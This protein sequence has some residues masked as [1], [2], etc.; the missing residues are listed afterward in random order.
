MGC[1]FR[2]WYGFDIDINRKPCQIVWLENKTNFHF[3]KSHDRCK[4]KQENKAIFMCKK[5]VRNRKTKIEICGQ[6]DKDTEA[7]IEKDD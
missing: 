7:K 4:I 2:V 3:V 1:C 5:E 6:S